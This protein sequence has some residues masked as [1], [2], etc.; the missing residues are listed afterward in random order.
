MAKVVEQICPEKIDIDREFTVNK[1][2]G[3]RVLSKDAELLGFVKDIIVKDF[4]IKGILISRRFRL[5]LRSSTTFYLYIDRMYF[6]TFTEEAVI[7]NIVPVTSLIGLPVLD[8]NGR[9]LGIVSHVVR[10][11][12]KNEFESFI[13]RKGFKEKKYMA[14]DIDKISEN[15]IL[16]REDDR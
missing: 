1:L 5:S 14:S 12:T 9:K 7:L 15:I 8:R 13:V 2:I 4:Q 10:H 16:N 3:K 6:D 11:D